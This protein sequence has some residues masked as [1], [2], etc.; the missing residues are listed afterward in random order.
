[1]AAHAWGTLA[2]LYS[3]QAC[4]CSVNTRIALATTRKNPLSISDYYAKMSQLADDLAASGTPLHDDEFI[5]YLLTGLDKD[6][7]LVFTRANPLGSK[8]VVCST[9]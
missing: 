7:N 8:R 3:S 2:N 9:F 5:A 4:A 6:Y 1:M